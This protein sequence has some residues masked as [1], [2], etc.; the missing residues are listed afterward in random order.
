M[1]EPTLNLTYSKLR[2][3]I[4]AFIGYSR[5]VAD[6]STGQTAIINDALEDGQRLFY[7]PPPIP[8]M[9]TG[10]PMV[11]KWSFLET[12]AKITLVPAQHI[13]EAPD[14]LL[15][16]IGDMTY[17]SQDFGNRVQQLP[18]ED[19]RDL[20]QGDVSSTFV[21]YFA[22]RSAAH[23]ATRG[24]RREFVFWPEPDVAYRRSYRYRTDPDALTSTLEYARGGQTHAQTLEAA[25]LS[26][27][28]LKIHNQPGVWTQQIFPQRLQSSIALDAA[29]F[30]RHVG[31]Q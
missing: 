31:S 12:A 15:Y 30:P 26:M 23:D 20:R 4:A 29:G 2:T 18:E 16:V 9:N 10:R 21:D 7:S 6:W 24:H 8:G 27:V 17:D 11:Y 1:T 28:E 25:C 13:Y 22:V 19:I 14:D 5:T 3:S